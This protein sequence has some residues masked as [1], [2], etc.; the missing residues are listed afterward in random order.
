M[1][2]PHKIVLVVLACVW[3][4]FVVA[5]FTLPG[6]GDTVVGQIGGGRFKV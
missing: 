5:L 6:A 3:I 2:T 1:Q 4:T